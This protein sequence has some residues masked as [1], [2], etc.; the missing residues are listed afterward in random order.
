MQALV[1]T[2]ALIAAGHRV[3]PA[4]GKAT[5]AMVHKLI[6]SN[7]PKAIPGSAKTGS[8]LSFFCSSIGGT[9]A[10]G[11][12]SSKLQKVK[13]P[14]EMWVDFRAHTKEPAWKHPESKAI[15]HPKGL[16]CCPSGRPNRNSGWLMQR[17]PASENPNARKCIRVNFSPRKI[18]PK[19]AAA[20]MSMLVRAATSPGEAPMITATTAKYLAKTCWSTAELN[21]K[22]VGCFSRW[23]PGRE[24]A[25]WTI[26]LFWALPFWSMLIHFDEPSV[27]WRS[28]SKDRAM[29]HLRSWRL[30]S[31]TPKQYT[32]RPFTRDVNMQPP[33]G[34]TTQMDHESPQ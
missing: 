18:K 20:M 3:A 29:T 16:W 1:K 24:K 10:I 21:K 7:N 23:F 26:K 17:A 14:T 19:K 5:A 13:T 33:P 12:A 34:R 11:T 31:S 30:G 27:Q 8:Q 15:Q 2:V 22:T 28:S 9:R 6:N 25:G 32:A 4:A